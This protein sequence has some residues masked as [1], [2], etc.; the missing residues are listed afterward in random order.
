MSWH[1]CGADAEMM[2]GVKVVE[3]KKAEGK[4]EGY[5]AKGK[6]GKEENEF[7]RVGRTSPCPEHNMAG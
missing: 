5:S 3:T 4:R 6:G 7:V 2:V 1:F